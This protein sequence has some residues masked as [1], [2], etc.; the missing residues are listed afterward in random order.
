M[1]VALGMGAYYRPIEIHKIENPAEYILKVWLRDDSRA[2]WGRLLQALC[3][4]G[5]AT[6]TITQ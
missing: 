3:I 1:A 6:E 5:V 2:T 4:A